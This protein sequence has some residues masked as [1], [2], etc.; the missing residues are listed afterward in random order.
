MIAKSTKQPTPRSPLVGVIAVVGCDGSGK[1]TLTADLLARLRNEGPTELLY[2]GQDSG[3]ILTW[4]L[5]VPLIGHAVGRYLLRKSERA[6]AVDDKPT[7]P[8]TLTALV[9]HL[10]SCWR[11]HKFRR[12]LELNRQGLVVITDRYP[13]AEMPGFHFDGPG[14]TSTTNGI[15]RW[16]TAR[17]LRLYEDM[18][19]H[20]PTLVIRLNVD[21]DTAHARK[22]DHK[23]SSLRDKVRVIPT[24]TFNGARVLD[25]D[26]RAPYPQV[27]QAALA[28]ALTTIASSPI[29]DNASRP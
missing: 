2:L 8:D 15:I 23:L 18:A 22:P 21:A 29:R 7:S 24:L 12:M 25:L 16:L 14:L 11:R 27:F 13:Q 3:N 6:H 10:L 9:I 20:V 28:A 17:E 26:A 5:G 4:I 19:N 1:S